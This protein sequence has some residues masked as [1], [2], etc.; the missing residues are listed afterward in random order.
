[1]LSQ[2]NRGIFKVLNIFTDC[3]H[4]FNS[5]HLLIGIIS[6]T[7]FITKKEKD[8]GCPCSHGTHILMQVQ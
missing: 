2:W 4:S 7:G 3:V 8:D 6:E 1:M 5:E